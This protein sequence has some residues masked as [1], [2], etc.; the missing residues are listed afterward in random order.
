MGRKNKNRV[1]A[2]NSTNQSSAGKITGQK[3][4]PQA[5][6][7]SGKQHGAYAAKVNAQQ[8]KGSVVKSTPTQKATA[9]KKKRY[10]Q[11]PTAKTKGCSH[12]QGFCF[13]PKNGNGWSSEETLAIQKLLAERKAQ[14][15]RR[16]I[17]VAPVVHNPMVLRTMTRRALVALSKLILDPKTRKLVNYEFKRRRALAKARANIKVEDLEAVIAKLKHRLANRHINRAKQTATA[18][19]E[20]TCSNSFDSLSEVS[21]EDDKPCLPLTRPPRVKKPKAPKPNKKAAPQALKQPRQAASRDPKLGQWLRNAIRVKQLERMPR[22]CTPEELEI[23]K[24]GQLL[25]KTILAGREYIHAV[26]EME[27]PSVDGEDH[28]TTEP[29]SNVVLTTQRDSSVAT[30]SSP[31]PRWSQWTTNDVVDSYKTV[32]DRWYQINQTIWKKDHQFDA[33]LYRLVLP[34]EL[35]RFIERNKDAVCDVPNTIPFRVHA[36]WRGDL[37]IKIQI[38]SNK[39]Q[40]GQLQATWYYNDDL[41]AM[42]NTKRSVY[43][44]S[45]MEHV[46]IS[47]SS[48]NE[49]TIRIPFKS[50]YPFLPT[51]DSPDWEGNPLNMGSLSLR[52]LAPLRMSATGPS[53]CS[54][55]TFIK[56]VNSEFTGTRT[57]KLYKAMPEMDLLAPVAENLLTN[58][59]GGRNMDNPPYAQAPRYFVPTG[60]HSLS[61]GTSLAEPLQALRLDAKGQT[62]HM[63]GCDPDEAMTVSSI[64]SHYGLIKQVVWSKDK[65]MGAKLFSVDADPFPTVAATTGA[66]DTHWVP[67]VGVVA[68]NF[69]YWR[70]S[71][72]YRFD[73]IASQ[74]HTGRLLVGY[75]PAALDGVDDKIDINTIK[76]SPYVVY[77]LQEGNSF[78]FTVPYVSFRPWWPRKYAGNYPV[79]T[80][81]APSRLFLLV[82]VPLVP[83]ESVVAEVHINVYL[84]GASSFEVSVPVQPCFGLN[85]NTQFLLRNTEE[86]RALQGYA[87]YYA[88]TWHSFNKG[89]SLVFRWG[90]LSDQ[91]AQWP[92]VK[93][94]KDMATYF[95]LA[96]P[97]DAP[98]GDQPWTFMVVWPSGHGYSI[99]IPTK[100]EQA[101]SRL[102]KLLY[103]GSSLGDKTVAANFVPSNNQGQGSYS[104][105]NPVWE[106]INVSISN[107]TNNAV[108]APRSEPFEWIAA[109]GEDKRDTVMLD[110][111]TQL[112]ATQFGDRFFGENFNDLK[113]LC[114]RYQLYGQINIADNRDTDIDHCLLTFPCLP[115]GLSLDIGSGDRINE[116]FN[117]CRDGIIPLISSGYRYYR[118]GLRFKLVLPTNVALNVWVQHRPDRRMM[119]WDD[120][121]ISACSAVTTGQGTF[122]HGYAAY[123]QVTQ[124]NNIVEF[125]VPFYNATCYNLLQKHKSASACDTYAVSLGEIAVGLSAPSATLTQLVNKPILVYYALADDMQFSSWVGYQPV[126]I[127]DKLPAVVTTPRVRRAL[128]EG[129]GDWIKSKIIKG[130]REPIDEIISEQKQ[131]VSEQVQSVVDDIH[132]CVEQSGPALSGELKATIFGVVSQL[133][134]AVLAKT[135][136]QVAWAISSIFVQIGIFSFDLA[137]AAKDLILRILQRV[138]TGLQLQTPPGPGVASPEDDSLRSDV[139][140]W[141]STVYTGVCTLFAIKR[142]DDKGRIKTW[143]Q[144]F[145]K[146]FGDSCR[147]SNQVFVFVRNTFDALKRIFEYVM[148]KTDGRA[149][150]IQDMEKCPEFLA[151]WVRECLIL[152]SPEYRLKRADDQSYV[153]RV[154][155]AQS[156]G[157]VLVA[158]LIQHGGDKHMATICKVYDK[159]CALKTDLMQAGKNPF[160]RKECFTMCLTG[161][162]G[163]GKSFMVDRLTGD[164]LSHAKTPVNGGLKCIVSPLSQ[165]WDQCEGQPVLAVDDMFAVESEPMLSLQLAMLFLVHSPIALSPPKADLEG[166]KMRYNPEIFVYNTNK[167]FPR[168]DRIMPEAIYRRRHELIEVGDAR[169]LCSQLRIGECSDAL[170][171]QPVQGC[172]HCT[173]EATL[174]QVDPELLKDMHHIRLRRAL[175]VT[176]PDT[177]WS[178]WYTYDQFMAYLKPVYLKNRVRADEIFRARCE[179]AQHLRSLEEVPGQSMAEL[180]AEVN[181]KQVEEYMNTRTRTLITDL[182]DLSGTVKSYVT[183][184]YDKFG[185]SV[186][187]PQWLAKTYK[188][189]GVPL[190][191]T[192]AK[193]LPELNI[194][195]VR[196]PDPSYWSMPSTSKAT[197]EGNP[198]EEDDE[199]V[200]ISELLEGEASSSGSFGNTAFDNAAR[201]TALEATRGESFS[202]LRKYAD[203]CVTSD[204]IAKRLVAIAEKLGDVESDIDAVFDLPRSIYAS[205]S[206]NRPECVGGPI[207]RI[208]DVFSRLAYA[209]R[210]AGQRPECRHWYYDT[211]RLYVDSNKLCITSLRGENL[212]RD[213]DTSC[214]DD[215]IMNTRLGKYLFYANWLNSSAFWKLAY[216]SNRTAMPAYFKEDC[217]IDSLTRW[218]KFT[219]WLKYQYQR[220]MAPVLRAIWVFLKSHWLQLCLGLMVAV[221]IAAQTA[222]VVNCMR[223]DAGAGTGIGSQQPLWGNATAPEGAKY[224]H[225]LHPKVTKI[226]TRPQTAQAQAASQ[227]AAMLEQRIRDNMIIVTMN[228]PPQGGAVSQTN[229]AR[230]VL[231]RGRQIL[232]LRHYWEN[233][234]QAPE[235]TSFYASYEYNPQGRLHSLRG[236]RFVPKECEVTHYRGETV[237]GEGYESNIMVLTLPVQFP[238]G[239][240][241]TKF[242]ATE[243]DHWRQQ[244]EGVLVNGK[245]VQQLPFKSDKALS[246]VIDDGNTKPVYMVGCYTYP[247][248]G[249]GVCGSLLLATNLEKPILGVHVAGKSGMDSHGIA[250]P[251]FYESFH[252]MPVMETQPYDDV[253]EL[254]LQPVDL[255]TIKLE[256]A[257]YPYGTVPPKFALPQSTQTRIIPSCISG[258]FPVETEPNP[259][260]AKDARIAPHDPLKLG[261]E[262]YGLPTDDF[263]RKF[264]ARAQQHLTEKLIDNVQP[265]NGCRIRSMQEA[266]CGIPGRDGYDSI[267]WETSCGFP[268]SAIKPAS[269]TGKRWLFTMDT[270]TEGYRLRD[271][272]P[273]LR[274]L[275]EEQMEMRK[276]GIKPQTVF[277]DCLKDTCLPKE[278]CRIPG[279]TRVFSISPIQF[280]IPFRQYFLDFMA[281]Y[282]AARLRAEHGIGVNVNGPEWGEFAR[283]LQALGP[284]VLAGDYSNYGP[285]LNLACAEAAF[286]CIIDWIMHYT[287]EEDKVTLKRVLWTMAQEIL[288]SWHEAK[289]LV[290]RIMAGIPSGSPITDILNTLT[291]GIYMRCAWQGLV[292]KPLSD[293]DSHVRLLLYGDDVDVNISDE[294]SD[295]FN[296]ETLCEYFGKHNIK[297]TD[298]DKSDNIVKWRDLQSVTF[299]KRGFIPHPRRPCEFL[300]PLDKKSVEGAANWVRKGTPK[301]EA[302]VVNAN[303]CLELAFGWGPAYYS[304]VR[305]SLRTA[306][307]KAGLRAVFPTWDEV[308]ERC[309]GSGMLG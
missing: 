273:E 114:R 105:G 137:N 232:I 212:P 107:S 94:V 120:A 129:P 14:N 176:N 260:S 61:L 103:S 215:C 157:Q 249:F 92:D 250:E 148:C 26:P 91:I 25:A 290:Y 210:H 96:V 51:A 165:Y 180:H 7:K 204:T 88:G 104:N 281:S 58:V 201:T 109:E 72:E 13:C 190:K 241:L 248:H 284:K 84:R 143:S 309:F 108:V 292:N 79:S 175:D 172:K 41:N 185:P 181:R 230:C 86:Y 29:S 259:L 33:E 182:Q 17:A 301:G 151:G 303:Q 99:G 236:V 40:V 128:P 9:Y 288:C 46:L 187:V 121:R 285:G 80:T 295:V 32:T 196:V 245:Y 200:I 267:S 38:N 253:Q 240:N 122:N 278:K 231:I 233:W 82:Q 115:Q 247:Y 123:I 306:L 1:V 145:M 162:P 87:P 207:N 283:Y 261:C 20:L 197:P 218:D 221:P 179:D 154:F 272:H 50:V 77:D 252:E 146:D 194:G 219:T 293:F 3:Q 106:R 211:A 119:K 45:Q 202:T 27:R 217:P 93:R 153:E 138:S 254:E 238:E 39:F 21:L 102:A 264:V 70:G 277:A 85:W 36:Y 275:M 60:A 242:F 149:R 126:I 4:Q 18:S 299:L 158:Q 244:G 193:D 163:V 216:S 170:K 53:E 110:T 298:A 224:G 287:E 195:G 276:N 251:L 270:T 184:W 118:G 171:Y 73:V 188:A 133:V 235:G 263:P 257:L 23:R 168:Y 220:S 57:G 307:R 78:T 95:K 75:V 223:S 178:E 101:A 237:S 74:F 81:F 228:V 56:L 139:A 63:V 205:M 5:V 66:V 189:C 42:I 208:D 274:R 164:L 305:E 256:T 300:A 203:S 65:T 239:R 69:M 30:T 156:F 294:I 124:V 177:K 132:Q 291:N 147:A 6:S 19:F 302:T 243:R 100:T 186:R 22:A 159:I 199:P 141:V 10:W 289:N 269:E 191:E 43:G 90:T 152:D 37:E 144:F 48:S 71:L 136:T 34:R 64:A 55:V 8:Q 135:W 161:A 54:V 246:F 229:S 89:N 297:F 11:K 2:S 227:Q 255:S 198:F 225:Q 262:K 286:G 52:V 15:A 209:C 155:A 265:I 234:M 296:M 192:K 116:T 169:A 213:V 83:M 268:L 142:T 160:I 173:G 130:F 206:Q 62:Q 76:S 266:V 183:S 28:T 134:H 174:D 31:T 166:K 47:A 140:A 214:G 271:I 279:K 111:T 226:S 127:L 16:I 304:E 59:L 49:A 308:D 35:L 280:T 167:P 222:L 112:A 67:P 125:E 97:E 24:G 12:G 113:T 68:G 258:V 117:R 282:R 44:F 150:L 98:Q 131:E